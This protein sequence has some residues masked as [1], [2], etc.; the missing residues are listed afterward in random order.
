MKIVV[1]RCYGGFCLSHVAMLRYFE[2]KEITVYPKPFSQYSWMYFTTEDEDY[3]HYI[4]CSNIER[5]DPILIQVVE[6]L[7]Q[8][9]NGDGAELEVVTIPDDVA[10]YITDYDGREKIVENSRTW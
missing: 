3:D 1:N 9:A 5:T 8:E 4:D 6:E 10:Y 7:G 2:L